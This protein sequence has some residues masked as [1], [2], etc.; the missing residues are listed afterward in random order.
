[1]A[2]QCVPTVCVER[3]QLCGFSRPANQRV[4]DDSREDQIVVFDIMLGRSELRQHFR[5]RFA[6]DRCEVTEK[7]GMPRE[8]LEVQ[9]PVGSVRQHEVRGSVQS[10]SV[11]SLGFERREDRGVARNLLTQEL[12]LRDDPVERHPMGNLLDEL[13]PMGGFEPKHGACSRPV[14][15]EHVRQRIR[16]LGPLYFVQADDQVRDGVVS[17]QGE[18]DV[19]A[20]ARVPVVQNFEQQLSD[21][22]VDPEHL[23]ERDSLALDVTPYGEV[24]RRTPL[25]DANAS[26]RGPRQASVSWKT[27]PKHS[28]SGHSDGEVR[29]SARPTKSG[30]IQGKCT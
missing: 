21:G 18:E 17:S 7:T 12:E 4:L 13:S 16:C 14:V 11:P 19:S 1:M 28:S 27:S 29:A 23:A 15:S 6:R 3:V 22:S 25:L 10:G 30:S 8:V 9:L 20:E 24:R 26:H 5:F 2:H